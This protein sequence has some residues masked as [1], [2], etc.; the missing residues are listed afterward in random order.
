MGFLAR[1]LEGLDRAPDA[2]LLRCGEGST[3][4]G[5]L[6]RRIAR[7]RGR[8]RA[9]GVR[10]GDRVAL[11]GDNGADW[12][13]LDLAIMAEGALA[14]PLYARLPERELAPILADAAPR[15]VLRGPFGDDVGR[16]EVVAPAAPS[17]RRRIVYT[18]GT[19]GASKGV[20]LTEPNI[21]F[22]LQRTGARLDRLF[23]GLAEP[24]RIFHYLPFCFAGSWILLS[25]ALL[26]GSR[27][28][29]CSDLKRI[30]EEMAAADPHAVL[31]VPLLLERLR[32]GILEKVGRKLLW[33]LPFLRG[34]LFGRAIRK[35]LCPSLRAMICGSAP[36]S[37][38]TQRFF[39]MLGME[40]LQVYGLTETTAI[41]TMDE[42][43][44]AVPGR[45]GSAI[46]G[47]EMRLSEAGEILVRGA[48]LFEGYWGEPPREGWFPTGDLGDVDAAGRWRIAGRKKEMLVLA[49]GHN[50]AP[51]AVERRIA[52]AGLG[53]SV[54]V[55]HGRPFLVAILFGGPGGDLEQVNATLPH[56]E[57]VRAVH[58]HPHP[59]AA[60]P[61]LLTANGKIRRGEV[62]TR[63]AREVEGL[64]A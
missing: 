5:S 6:A 14:V 9:E 20:V 64:Y 35:R 50:V 53:E 1:I 41:C 63:F 49:S 24:E 25:T 10:A 12:I 18:S 4:A 23:A 60:E 40:V 8:L 16:D 52:E 55:G 45:V 59:L 62:L 13:A 30:P 3:T 56:F 26:R 54:V 19:S 34:P 58:I 47:V 39:M 43:G 17:H 27:L 46:D 15:A 48:N 28:T 33:K 61:G 51:E 42:P 37:E 7:A 36:L 29:L 32:A 21:D 38:E 31:N 2:L 57:R 44:H 22:M 11:I